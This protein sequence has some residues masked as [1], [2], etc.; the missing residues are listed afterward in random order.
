VNGCVYVA[1]DTET[2]PV[3]ADVALMGSSVIHSVETATD[4]V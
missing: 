2:I 4:A 1:R 3:A